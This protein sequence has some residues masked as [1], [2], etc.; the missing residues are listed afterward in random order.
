MKIL[1]IISSFNI[2]SRPVQYQTAPISSVQMFSLPC[3]TVSFSG[4]LQG[5]SHA[6]IVRENSQTVFSFLERKNCINEAAGV[7]EE[8]SND[9]YNPNYYEDLNGERTFIL[10]HVID[11]FSDPDIADKNWDDLIEITNKITSHPYFEYIDVDSKTDLLAEA[12]NEGAT[13]VAYAIMQT[14][15]FEEE[16]E[17]GAIEFYVKIARA[18][19]LNDIVSELNNIAE[20][21]NLDVKPLMAK[22]TKAQTGDATDKILT[23]YKVIKGEN[24]PNNL[25]EVGGMF[26]AK[27]DIQEFIV[28]PWDNRYRQKIIDN[29][30]N[31][32]SGFLLSGP[33]G[34]GKTYILK[35]I[36]A[37]TG[38]D[39]YEVNL[40]NIGTSEA[41]K[42]QSDLVKLFD[43]LEKKY[44]ETGEPSI[45]LLDELDSIAMDRKKCHTDWKKDDINALLMVLNNSA[46]RGIIVVGATNNPED[47]DEA[48]K[49]AGRLDKQL[50]I[51]LP[52]DEERKD[53]IEKILVDKK[54]AVDLI[55]NADILADKLKGHS[56][57]E[58]SAILNEACL[59]AIYDDKIYAGMDDFEYAVQNMKF[60]KTKGRTVIKG[61]SA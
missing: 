52:T 21:N 23:P 48:V 24:D 47:L 8:Y 61:F 1:P 28:K 53:I 16:L 20:E 26:Q 12:I 56:P 27:K 41:Y 19:G 4:N 44:K 18:R 17:E 40:S 37:E 10:S 2:T 38:Y 25:G 5:Q 59:H 55:M 22:S 45:L 51:E 9:D 36:S 14:R 60:E 34:C 58:I 13:E 31:R 39:L 33:P 3:D 29:K 43:A 46:S 11:K 54:I 42:T 30:L 49:R 35:A 6:D 50:K 32:P 57:A 7:L 15:A